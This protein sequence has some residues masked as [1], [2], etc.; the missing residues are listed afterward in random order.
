MIVNLMIGDEMAGT[1]NSWKARL[2]TNNATVVTIVLLIVGMVIVSKGIG[3][4]LARSKKGGSDVASRI[5]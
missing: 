4:L 1:L 2:T 5:V 3:G